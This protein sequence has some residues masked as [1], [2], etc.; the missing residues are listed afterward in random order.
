M[1]GFILAVPARLK[2]WGAAIIAALLA[3]LAIYSKGRS[4]AAHKAEKKAMQ[5]DLKAHE[6]INDA[7]LGIG[8]TDD[9]R[10]D[11]LREFAARHGTGPAEGKGG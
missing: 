5:A 6:R 8:A 10:I 2:V 4:D 7:D 3:L 11:R 1:I 9:Q